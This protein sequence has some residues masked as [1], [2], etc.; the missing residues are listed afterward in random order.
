M[1]DNMR[2]AG[3]MTLSMMA[4]TLNDACMKAA[5]TEVPLFQA[6]FLRG[7]LTTFCLYLMVRWTGGLSFN[8]PPQDRWLVAV[9]SIAEMVTAF[10]FINAIFNIPLA[11]A[12]AI[13]STLPLTVTLA[14]AVFLGEPVGWRRLLAIGIGFVGVLLIVRPGSEGFD[15][16]SVYVL[17][18]VVCVTI[19]DITA[20]KVSPA[21]PSTTMA[22]LAAFAVTGFGG[23]MSLTEPWVALS[24]FAYLMLSGA[25]CAIIGG[26]LFSV[27]VMR[28]GEIAFV[29]PFRY[30]SLIAALLLGL[31]FFSEW[32]DFWTLIGTG[33]IAGT[34]LFTFYRE[35]ATALPEPVVDTSRDSL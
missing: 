9:R 1:T 15:K 20:R 34:G 26:Y 28:V 30:T 24:P 14:G 7:C 25:A 32:P 33:L 31:V 21:V 19:R 8:W 13:I 4:F 35:R 11:N 22:V 27:M 17:L 6:I 3:L 16:Y 10:F 12:T 18:A 5:G 2:G 23:V 29:A